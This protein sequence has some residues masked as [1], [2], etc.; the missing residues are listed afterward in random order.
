MTELLQTVCAV[1][2]AAGYSSRM[3]GGPKAL[4]PLGPST[5]LGMAV[6]SLTEAGVRRIRV[7]TGHESFSVGEEALKHKAKPVYNRD[8]AKGMFSSLCA[9]LEDIVRA[10]ETGGGPVGAFFLLPVDAAPV[11]AQSMAAMVRAWLTLAPEAREKAVL[12][13]SFA[14]RTGHPPLLG[15]AHIRKILAWRNKE[16][17]QERGGLREYLASQLRPEAAKFFF[18]GDVPPGLE[19]PAAPFA[20]AERTPPSKMND[21]FSGTPS[22]FWFLSLPDSGVLA[23]IDTPDDYEAALAL[24]AHSGNRSH[25]LP[26]EAWEWLRHSALSGR[27]IRHSLKVALGALRLTAALERA[28]RETDPMLAVCGGMLHDIGRLRKDHAGEG[29]AMVLAQGWPECSLI[30]G[31]HMTLPASLLAALGIPERDLPVDGEDGGARREDQDAARSATEDMPGAALQDLHPHSPVGGA[32]LHACVAVYLADKFYYGDTR[33]S[34]A[35]RFSVAREYSG[36]KEA[37]VAHRERIAGLVRNWF[38]TAAGEDPETAL[39]RPSGNV[40]EAFLLRL[41]EET[42]A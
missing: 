7:V 16:C 6:N 20:E 40:R 42:A 15:A 27:K 37:A 29:Q 12:L 33:V 32:L 8:F 30:V 9:G 1:I 11:R 24:L 19:I 13:P 34:L 28:G 22:P 18:L 31:A 25:P 23:D 10:E 36:G 3:G 39:S 21:L 26:E 4:L 5:M 2:P 38:R 14:G 35:R 41:L 17:P